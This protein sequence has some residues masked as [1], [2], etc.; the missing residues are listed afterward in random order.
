MRCLACGAEMRLMQVDLVTGSID[1][2]TFK[3]SDCSQIARR[4]MFSRAK[5]P[6]NDL[7]IL[8]VGS[9]TSGSE[10]QVERA[11]AGSAWEKAVG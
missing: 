1:R 9:K 6:A 3:C 10:L 8:I 5:M 11:A 4:L 7:P 2:H